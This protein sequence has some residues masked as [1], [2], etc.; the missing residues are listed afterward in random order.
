MIDNANCS[1]F[2]IIVVDVGF[3]VNMACN[4]WLT[5]VELNSNIQKYRNHCTVMIIAL[6]ITK[7]L[8]T[9][10]HM[11]AS[12]VYGFHSFSCVFSP[13]VARR[14]WC[15]FGSGPIISLSCTCVCVRGGGGKDALHYTPVS[16]QQMVERLARPCIRT[17]HL[18]D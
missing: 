14:F 13:K 9:S 2:I 5:Y 12:V 15:G 17:T 8:Y 4:K 18:H 11:H 16:A 7:C 3:D 10:H 6:L 1:N